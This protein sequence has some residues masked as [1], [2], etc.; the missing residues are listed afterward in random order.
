MHAT[1]DVE[2]AVTA[3]RQFLWP[4]EW[5]KWWR[6]ALV[7]LFL[8]GGTGV[9]P[10]SFQPPTTGDAPP[11]APPGPAEPGVPFET[12]PP[13]LLALAVVIGIAAAIVGLLFAV[14]GA[15]MEFVLVESLRTE[16]VTVRRYI[17]RRWRQGVRLLVFQVALGVLTF[18]VAGGLVALG[19]APVILADAAVLSGALLLIAVPVALMVVLLAGAVF[20]FTSS[21]VVPTMVVE[22]CG[23]LDG[24]RRFWPVLRRSWKEYLAYALVYVGLLIVAGIAAGIV[25]GIGFVVLAIPFGALGFLGVALLGTAGVAG[26]AFL[27][28][29]GVLF[30]LAVIALFAF[31][32]VPIVTFLR[33]YSL[34]LLGDTEQTLDLIAERRATVRSEG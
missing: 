1:S 5:S 29:V 9:S 17:G 10:P 4:F 16:R 31:V 3:T 27:A 19:L 23:V 8:G 32:Q 6:L 30:L 13:D 12:I 2:D 28:V 14:L 22:D 7:A 21:F 11:V 34:L 24:W 26:L 18:L 33:Y 15:I 25:I 20:V